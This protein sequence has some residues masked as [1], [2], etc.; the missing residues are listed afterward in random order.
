MSKR[1]P[2]AMAVHGQE[3][4][5]AVAE[6]LN[7]HKTIMGDKVKSFQSRVATLFGKKH[8][9]M[10]NSGSSAN[11]LAVE[12][13]NLPAGS[14]VIT[15]AMTF[16]TTV[17]PLMQKGLV[18][19]FTDAV[20]GSYLLNIDQVEQLITPKTKALMVPSLLGNVP[21]YP[22]LQKIAKAHDLIL[23]EDS[24]DTLGATINDQPTGTYT[25]I[26]TTS[27]YGSHIIT[28]GG[29]GGMI[30][31]N[32]DEW[33]RDIMVLRGWGRSSAADETEDIETRF[34]HELDGQPHDSKF[35][36]EVAGYNFL[37]SEIGAAF[38][39][40]QL[41]KLKT[42]TATRLR[43]FTELLKF[44]QQY[45][46]YFILPQQAPEV[47]TSW[48]A[49]PLTIKEGAPFTRMEVMKYLEEHNV[50]TRPT[51]S[52]NLLRH[53]GFKHLA[54]RGVGSYPV[55]DNI[56]RHAFLTACHHGLSIEDIDY[57]KQLMADFIQ[58]KK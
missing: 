34:S 24:C 17:A 31:V 27:F 38:G 15:P 41:D 10:V 9:V 19:V 35:I 55:S 58:S 28:A 4:F 16:S 7:T 57:V 45:E 51:F 20:E 26:S 56:M 22:R 11:L 44:Y 53:P 54:A 12:V 32:N 37:P 6:V 49:F 33:L 47:K 5:D 23:I 52:G 25:D 43:N 46:E 3:E 40:A 8:G 39:L 13:M 14:E 1:I 30:C 29:G 18:P 42:F 48:L 21:D 50:Q 2:Y 36:F